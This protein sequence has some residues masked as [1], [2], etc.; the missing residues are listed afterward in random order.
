[1]VERCFMC[2]E[3]AYIHIDNQWMCKM[4]YNKFVADS[5]DAS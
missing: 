3:E 5:P 1:M 2:G 4:H